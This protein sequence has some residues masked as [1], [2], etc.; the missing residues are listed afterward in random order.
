M[1]C[2]LQHSA[3]GL[4]FSQ[5]WGSQ[6]D[7]LT[8]MC[9]SEMWGLAHKLPRHENHSERCV[10]KHMKRLLKLN[11]WISLKNNEICAFVFHVTGRIVL[12]LKA[13][14][15]YFPWTANQEQSNVDRF[16]YNLVTKERLPSFWVSWSEGL[17]W[18]KFSFRFQMFTLL[19]CLRL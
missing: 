4:C 5:C 14:A 1:A 10:R 8:K 19:T 17:V 2:N 16:A 9:T 11:S 7:V 12:S 3:V 13:P 18:T 15:K 6:K